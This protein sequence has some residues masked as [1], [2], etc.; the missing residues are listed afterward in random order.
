MQKKKV[1]QALGIDGNMSPPSKVNGVAKRAS[2]TCRLASGQA[3]F[4]DGIEVAI[5]TLGF[6][7]CPAASEDGPPRKN[8]Y[9]R[10]AQRS[11]RTV[12]SDH[13]D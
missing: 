9:T 7:I 11:E 6:K 12:V 13:D 5:S 1:R 4:T 8:V 10:T 3:A 2:H